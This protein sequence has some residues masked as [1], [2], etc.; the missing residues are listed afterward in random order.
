MD[1]LAPDALDN[2]FPAYERLRRDQPVS[3]A[4]DLGLWLVSRYDTCEQVLMNPADFSS[5]DSVSRTN[6]YRGCPAALA[7]LRTSKIYPRTRTLVVTD[8]PEHRRHRK[9]LVS[10]LALRSALPTLRPQIQEIVDELIDDFIGVGEVEFVEQFAYPLP[11]RVIALF[12][13]VP[14]TELRMLKRWSDSFLAAQAANVDDDALVEA[15]HSVLEFEAYFLA[16]IHDRRSLGQTDFLGRLVS[17]TDDDGVGLSNGELLSLLT[18][19]L[20]GGNESTRNF[21]GS[22]LHLIL[23][24]PGLHT[25]LA[26][27]TTRI[28][29]FIEEAIRLE[30][31]LQGLYRTATREI[32]LEGQIIPEGARLMVMFGS[33]NRDESR[34][35]NSFDLDRNLTENPHLAFGRGIHACVGQSLARLESQLAFETLLRRLP[36]LRLADRFRNDHVPLYGVRGLQRLDLSFVADPA[37]EGTAAR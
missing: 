13:D 16:K 29:A 32:E 8:P 31:P 5:R 20:V 12:L 2:P 10:S 15:S 1:L 6:P 24:E 30:S 36:N 25:T 4:E 22:A 11:M 9:A 18:Q 7:V 3:Y 14:H 35:D 21:L 34:Y 17:W 23:T 19:T 33:A 26:T 37:A 28:A 27:D